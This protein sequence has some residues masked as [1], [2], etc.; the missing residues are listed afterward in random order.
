MNATPALPADLEAAIAALP[1]ARRA[2]LFAWI[3]ELVARMNRP[4]SSRPRHRRPAILGIGEVPTDQHAPN[5]AWLGRIGLPDDP[6][7]GN[8]A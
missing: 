2:A 5:P 3:R 6:S 4:A 7:G 1:D 8:A